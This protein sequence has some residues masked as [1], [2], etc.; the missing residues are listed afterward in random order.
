MKPDDAMPF[1][2]TAFFQAVQGYSDAVAM[3]YM[4]SLWHY[5]HHTHCQGLP[6]DDDYLRRICQCDPSLWVRTKGVIFDDQY[7]FCK[8][9]DGKWHQKNAKEIHEKELELYRRRVAWAENARQQK[10]NISPN[11]N[12]NIS[13]S[14]NIR[15]EK[16]L[17]RV[18]SKLEEIKGQGSKTATGILFS[19]AQKAELSALRDRRKQLLDALDFK[20]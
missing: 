13:K 3:G 18:E 10:A 4:R 15:N 1:F 6:D 19:T 16:E 14:D 11:N 7:F 12:P 17:Q 20:A 9:G 2:G 5:Y 8:N